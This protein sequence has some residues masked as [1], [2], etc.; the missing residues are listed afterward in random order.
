MVQDLRDLKDKMDRLV[1]G[2]IRARGVRM[3]HR[4]LRDP[5]VSLDH[6]E[7]EETLDHLDSQE[8]LVQP[9]LQ[10]IAE[11]QDRPG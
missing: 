7:H 2:E 4:D 11:T 10:A 6:L 3:D 1:K 9:E 8:I 5:L